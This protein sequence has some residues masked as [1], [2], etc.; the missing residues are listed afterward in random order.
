MEYDIQST[1]SKTDTFETGSIFLS[2]RD[3]LLVES[4]LNNVKKDR[5]QI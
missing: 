1:L 2:E 5:D 4:Q 3:V